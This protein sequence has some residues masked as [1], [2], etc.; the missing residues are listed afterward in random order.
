MRQQLA[1]LG[2]TGSVGRSVLEVVRHHPDRLGVAA[3]A[4]QGSDLD[5]V[6]RQVEE[7]APSIVAIHDADRAAELAARSQ[8]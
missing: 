4:A 5:L 2:S 8:S 6:A 3:L 1:V 7:F